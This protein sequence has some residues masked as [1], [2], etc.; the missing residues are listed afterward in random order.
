MFLDYNCIIRLDH[1]DI[2]SFLHYNTELDFSDLDTY[3]LLALCCT[4]LLLKKEPRRNL[5]F[6]RFNKI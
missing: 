2:L 5:D 6:I 3:L 4:L 1:V